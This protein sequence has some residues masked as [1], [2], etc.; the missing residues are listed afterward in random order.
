MA[1]RPKA[2]PQLARKKPT[3]K[4]AP[5]DDRSVVKGAELGRILGDPP[6]TDRWVR[7]LADRGYLTRVDRGLYDLEK[8]VKG[9][10]RFVRET[11]VRAAA[12]TPTKSDYDRERARRLKLANDEQ[13]SKLLDTDLGVAAVEL[14]VGMLRTDLAGV[15]ARITEDVALRRRAEDAIDTVLAGLAGRFAKAR[16]AL[17]QGRDPSE[18][19]E[20]EPA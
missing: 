1:Q 17:R 19:D 5:A 8:S 4:R 20:T 7:E 11:E 3:K 15:P 12:D 10:L 16:D 9:Y 14:I 2:S 6:F 18:A 13:E